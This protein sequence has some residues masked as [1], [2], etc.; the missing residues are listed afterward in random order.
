MSKK[1]QFSL[2]IDSI[3]GK[4]VDRTVASPNSRNASIK[5]FTTRILKHLVDDDKGYKDWNVEVKLTDYTTYSVYGNSQRYKLFSENPTCVVCG[6]TISYA[7]LTTGKGNRAHFN[8]FSTDDVLMTK[9]HIV[10]KSLGGSD[11]MDNYQ[12][13]CSICNTKKG[14]TIK[15]Y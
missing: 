6:R 11:L 3:T 4:V 12:T 10:P 14:A 1:G 15:K 5:K 8:F 7:L 13:M 9:D 2:R